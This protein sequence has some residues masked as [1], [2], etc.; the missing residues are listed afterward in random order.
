MIQVSFS[1]VPFIPSVPSL[2]ELGKMGRSAGRSS[3]TER[4]SALLASLKTGAS[5]ELGFTG[6]GRP[7][8]QVGQIPKLTIFQD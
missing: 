8:E 2:N 6:A 4:S 1:P 5:L 3:M 7:I